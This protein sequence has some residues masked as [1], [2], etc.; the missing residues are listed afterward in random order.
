MLAGD[1]LEDGLGDGGHQLVLLA[2]VLLAPVHHGLEHQQQ[3]HL[4]VVL[5]EQGTLRT[6]L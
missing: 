4:Q 1:V 6:T 3:Q 2:V 5:G